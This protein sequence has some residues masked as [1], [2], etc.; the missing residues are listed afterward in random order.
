MELWTILAGVLSSPALVGIVTLIVTARDR[1]RA[2]AARRSLA[3][4]LA[5]GELVS[6]RAASDGPVRDRGEGGGGRAA[7][8]PALWGKAVIGY[9]LR[10]MAARA[11]SAVTADQRVILDV[12]CL[13]EFFVDDGSAP[14]ARLRPE[15]CLPLFAPES[16]VPLDAED[17][18]RPPLQG[19]V[20]R[21]MLPA[22]ALVSAPAFVGVEHLLEPGETVFVFGE[23]AHELDPS[24]AEAGYRE[25][26]L[27][28]V[29]SAPEGGLLVV[30]DRDREELLQNLSEGRDLIPPD[31]TL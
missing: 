17:L 11:D 24:A 9:R 12:A 28:L 25:P 10:V 20:D 3:G 30:A 4:T 22:T 31:S 2:A 15:R 8:R 6:E 29:V 5:E 19:I 18:M 27:R 1:H 26:P 21:C 13:K 23:A 14:P 7:H 16:P